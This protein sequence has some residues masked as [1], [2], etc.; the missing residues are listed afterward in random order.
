LARWRKHFS[1]Q[2]NLHGVNNVRQTET[3]TAGPLVP[4]LNAFEIEMSIEKPKRHESPG[5]DQIP[6]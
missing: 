5:T 3:P 4:E 6:A 1:Q 2:L